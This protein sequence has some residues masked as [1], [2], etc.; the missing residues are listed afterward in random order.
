MLTQLLVI[1]IGFVVLYYGAEWLVRGAVRIA[2]HLGISKVVVGIVLVAFGTSSP[3][4]FVNLVAAYEGHSGFL[5]T[6]VSG[7]N[8]ANICIGFGVCAVTGGLVVARKKFWIYLG[9]FSIAPLL[10][11]LLVLTDAE[12]ELPF[13]SAGFFLLLFAT[14]LFVAKQR[15][16]VPQESEGRQKGKLLFGFLLFLIGCGTLY[17]GGELVI[18]SAVRIGKHLGVSDAILGLT[19]I[20]FG[21]SIPDVMASIVAVKK[22]EN[23]IAVGNLLGSNIFNVLFILS[24]TLLVLGEDLTTDQGIIVDYIMVCI[25]SF[26][27]I[28]FIAVSERIARISGI[29]LVAIYV[30]YITYRVMSHI[31]FS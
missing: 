11:L 29:V 19:V 13:W 31:N 26:L 25:C 1:I 17:A 6:N 23:S 9:Y 22:G 4:L 10:V 3:E 8:L 21:T 15:M 12:Q 24:A 5:L 28:A 2:V 14:Y 30:L 18:Q 20:A 27:F 7:S 16:D